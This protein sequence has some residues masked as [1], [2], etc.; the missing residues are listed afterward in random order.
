MRKLNDKVLKALC[1]LEGNADFRVIQEWFLESASDQD[2]TLRSAESA[3]ILYRAQGA[4]TELLEFCEIASTPRDLAGKLAQQKA[5]V[6]S[7][8]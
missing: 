7:I 8:P 6:R 2:K 5:G 3:P 1:N 4:V